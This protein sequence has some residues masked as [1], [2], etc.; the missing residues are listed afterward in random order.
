MGEIY[1]QQSTVMFRRAFRMSF[2]NLKKLFENV[3]NDLHHALGHDKATANIAHPVNGVIPL[4]VRLGIATRFF[5]GGD[6]YDI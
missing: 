4:S 6:P 2:T 5:A 1:C 3:H